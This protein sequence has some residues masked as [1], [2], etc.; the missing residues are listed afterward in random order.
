MLQFR[1]IGWVKQVH[2]DRPAATAASVRGVLAAVVLGVT[3]G[4]L[5]LAVATRL[6]S[7]IGS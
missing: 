3:L 1:N 6:G 5:V 4:L 2:L 7:A